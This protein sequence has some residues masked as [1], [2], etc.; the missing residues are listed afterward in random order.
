MAQTEYV[1][2]MASLPALGPMLAAKTA[3]INRVRLQKRL[4]E[5]LRPDH[6]AEIDA[7]SRI[8]DW[9]RLPLLTADADF[10][11]EARSVVPALQNETLRRL[12]QD[13]LEMRTVIAALRRRHAGKEAPAAAELWGYGPYVNRI[14]T[15][16]REPGFG[17]EHSFKWVLPAKEKLDVGDAAGLERILLEIAW[18]QADRLIGGHEFDFE[19]VALYVVRW[20][21]LDR[22][23][24]Y[25]AE[26][27]ATRFDALV[28]EALSDAPATLKQ[29]LT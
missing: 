18:R 3:P 11:R 24:R 16:W 28:A 20:N 19:A 4:R 12:V 22:W 29:Q 6:L 9:S 2:L 21:L 17:V 25:D 13:R 8:V 7:A 14:R 1:E 26:A 15:N 5:F 23:T 27:A 10:V